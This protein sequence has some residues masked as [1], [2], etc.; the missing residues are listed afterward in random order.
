MEKTTRA[1][2]GDNQ[3][4]NPWG[5]PV[6]HHQDPHKSMEGHPDTA[7]G[8]EIQLF[9]KGDQVPN[10]PQKLFP[11]G[12][13]RQNP[14]NSLQSALGATWVSQQVLRDK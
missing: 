13:K 11:D 12:Q 2:E 14:L 3:V 9:A 7:D 10:Q 5:C 6:W 1:C 8:F 4:F